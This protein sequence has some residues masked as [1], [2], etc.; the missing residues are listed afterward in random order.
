M[1]DLIELAITFG[2]FCALIMLGLLFGRRAEKRHFRELEQ[3]EA[4]MQHMLATQLTTCVAADP[5]GKTPTIIL[6]ETVVASDYLKSFLAKLRNI[7]GGNIRGFELLQERARREVTVQLKERAQESGYN[8]LCNVRLT[9]VNLMGL[10][11]RAPSMAT[12]IGTGT[13]YVSTVAGEAGPWYE[14]S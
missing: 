7:F 10:D 5:Q 3:R 8:A 1:S 6:A 9:S 4:R 14:R 12:V 2:T 11:P 13:A